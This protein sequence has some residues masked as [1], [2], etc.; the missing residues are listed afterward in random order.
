MDSATTA[1]A[2]VFRGKPVRRVHVMVKP[3]GALCNLDCTYCYYL[4]KQE[5]LGKPASWRIS[6]QLLEEF[7]RQYFD[8]QNCKVVVFS[9]QGGEPTLLGLEFFRKVVELEKKYCPPHVRCENDLQTNGTLLDDAWCEF[10]Y[11]NNFLVGLSID[12]PKHLHDAYRKDAAGQGSFDRVFQA[13]KLLRK[14]KVNFAALCCVNSVTAK[15]PLVIYRFLRDQVG[16]QRIQFIPVVEPVSFRQ[17]APQRW[18]E[19]LMPVLD[20]PRAMPGS[21]GTVVTEWS[22]VPDDWGDFLCRVFDEWYRKDL[23]RIYVN[24]FESAVETW[25]GHASPLCT[26]SHLCGKGLALERDG[27][28]YA[29]DHYVYP[30]YRTGN[31][32]ERP[33]ADM[34]FSA[35][36]EKFGR[37]KEGSLPEYCRACEYQFSCFGECPKNRFIRSPDGEAGLNYLCSGWKKFFSHIDQPMQRIVRGLGHTVNK[38]LRTRSADQWQPEK[39]Q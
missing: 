12:G 23:G 27:S 39:Q 29:C 9:W 33:L 18:D 26:L 5:L 30:E 21:E 31:I 25:M 17:V 8:S 32:Q 34:A 13:A 16:A 15:H 3:T 4:S 37:M 6:D 14:H 1:K 24:Y 38:G 19:R 22:V 7:I 28:V 11:E 2:P 20:S 36:Q 10:L 35:Q